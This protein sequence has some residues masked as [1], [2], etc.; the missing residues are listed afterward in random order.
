M[1]DLE[2]ILIVIFGGIVVVGSLI[3]YSNNDLNSCFVCKKP[4]KS[5]KQHRTWWEFDGTKRPV[6]LQCD[7]KLEKEV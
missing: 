7:K 3:Y 2:V 1:E 5:M 4:F 6:C